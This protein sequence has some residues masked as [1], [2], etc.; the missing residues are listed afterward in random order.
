MAK[1]ELHRDFR[2]F[3]K[4]L[5]SH[6]V[7]YLVVG[8]YAVGYY[9]YPRAT[10]DLDVWIELNEANARKTAR[11]LI[12]FGMPEEQTTTELFAVK[13]RVIRMG[14]PPVRIE[15]LTGATGVDF[16]EC[17]SR[18][19]VVEIE[20]LPVDFISLTDL[21]I[22]KQACRRNKDLEDLDHLP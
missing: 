7:K 3:L 6:G 22:N 11:A 21:K 9:G 20:G 16:A 15:V 19:E 5:N 2:D 14:V 4:S 17:Y 10:A 1:I 12:E 8:G 18:R 13:G